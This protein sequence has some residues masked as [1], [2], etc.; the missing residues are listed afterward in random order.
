M[1]F[2]EKSSHSKTP[3]EHGRLMRK[4]T[5]SLLDLCNLLTPTELHKATRNSST[6]YEYLR[7]HPPKERSCNANYIFSPSCHPYSSAHLLLHK[8]QCR[9]ECRK[10]LNGLF[11]VL[12]L[13]RD[14]NYRP[15]SQFQSLQL[16]KALCVPGFAIGGDCDFRGKMLCF[17]DKLRSWATFGGG[18]GGFFFIRLCREQGAGSRRLAFRKYVEWE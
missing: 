1:L 17:F 18:G 15:L 4:L 5:H 12:S 14:R 9:Q 13:S 3:S 2:L 16:E 8:F 10:M 6:A 7:G 11:L